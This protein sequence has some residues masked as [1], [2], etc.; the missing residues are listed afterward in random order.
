MLPLSWQRVTNQP[1]SEN[2]WKWYLDGS[3]INLSVVN[4]KLFVRI[5][6]GKIDF[7][8]YLAKNYK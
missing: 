3:I 4:K 2:D 5:G 7:M 6:G 1:D 8:Q